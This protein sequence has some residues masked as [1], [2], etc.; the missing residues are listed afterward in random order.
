MIIQSIKPQS[1]GLN[2]YWNNG[3]LLAAFLGFG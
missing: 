2:V 3:S 1:D